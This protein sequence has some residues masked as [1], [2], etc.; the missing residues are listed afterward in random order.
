[1]LWSLGRVTIVMLLAGLGSVHSDSGAWFRGVHRSDP[2]PCPPSKVGFAFH[3]RWL[4]IE[5]FSLRSARKPPAAWRLGGR[6][7]AV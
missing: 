2:A 4:T 5:R 1:M 6:T 3:L 7:S